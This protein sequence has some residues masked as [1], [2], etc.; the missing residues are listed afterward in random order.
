MNE[1]H[2][3]IR[4]LLENMDR[5]YELLEERYNKRAMD[6]E[7]RLSTIEYRYEEEIHRLEQ[8]LLS[9]KERIHD[10]ET[11]LLLI[12]QNSNNDEYKHNHKRF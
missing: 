11:Q 3:I 2:E 4:V 8:E 10:V 5:R 1:F 12:Q 9:L 6:M 7:R